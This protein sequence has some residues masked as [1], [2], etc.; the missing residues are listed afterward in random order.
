MAAELSE[1]ARNEFP[2]HDG[3]RIEALRL[4]LVGSF[5]KGLKVRKLAADVLLSAIIQSEESESDQDYVSGC[6]ADNMLYAHR[7]LGDIALDNAEPTVAVEHYEKAKEI[8]ERGNRDKW[9]VLRTDVW[10]AD[11]KAKMPNV[12]TVECMKKNLGLFTE[13]FELSKEKFGGCSNIALYAGFR[14]SNALIDSDQF[15]RCERQRLENYKISK[16]IHGEDHHR[17]KLCKDVLEAI[18]KRR[19]ILSNG[20]GIFYQVL[21][22]DKAEDEYLL[23]DLDDEGGEDETFTCPA[24]QVICRRGT[25]VICHGL[26]GVQEQLNGKLAEV[27]GWDVGEYEVRLEG[28][29]RLHHIKPSNV[30]VA[31]DLPPR[32]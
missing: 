26:T 19:C 9:L 7:E 30:R 1:F 12:D 4:R 23:K 2:Y 15:V 17:T 22:Y 31:I 14:L 3:L 21:E 5:Y 29:T 16:Q 27:A 10:I 32:D 20:D 18:Q 8:L 25:P 6:L 13:Y 24:D 28:E 11:A